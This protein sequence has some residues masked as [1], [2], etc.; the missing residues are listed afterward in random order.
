M[1]KIYVKIDG[2]HCN[3]CIDIISKELLKNKKISDVSFRKDIAII[4]YNGKLYN[5]E[6]MEPIIN[7]G[8]YTKNEYISNNIKD[9]DSSIKILE[10]IIILVIILFLWFIIN[11]IFG[12]NIFNIIPSIDSSITYG[13]LFVTGLL[14]SIH[15]ISMCGA[16]NLVAI[17]DN[18]KRNYKKPLLYNLGRVISYTL[19]GAISGLIGSVISFNNTIKG[20]VIIIA[21]II[22]FLMGF[23]ML[24]ILNHKI[25]FLNK[26]RLKN[27]TKNSFVIGLLNGLMPC[28]PLQAM[29][30]YA[31]ST[32]SIIKGALSMLLFSLGTVP[33]MLSAGMVY[34]FIKGKG[35][36]LINKVASILILILSI[37]MLNRGLLNIG[38][39]ITKNFNDYENFTPSILM[40]DYQVI[41]FDLEYTSYKDVIVQKDIPV[42]MIIHVDEKYLT[43]CNNVVDMKDF[44]L[45]KELKSGENI[46]EFTPN[47][48]GIYTY[49]CWMN[50]IKNNIK[51]IDDIKY[52]KENK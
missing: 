50:M 39:D 43:S 47:T 48:E 20:I 25:S 14:T 9:V 8:Y 11:K 45:Q 32:G 28:G 46:I 31:L 51:V 3:H 10:F 42:K 21:S 49:T 44:G 1:K 6:I 23:S 7:I 24:G 27:R 5:H 36:F 26:L 40:E 30:V 38:I 29:Q 35:K 41:E 17:V 15:C 37:V 18:E 2:I 19:I 33:L 13:M 34:N 12:Y 4:N 52:F 22:M 16:I